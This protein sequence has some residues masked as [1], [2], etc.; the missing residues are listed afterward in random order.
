MWSFLPD[1]MMNYKKNGEGTNKPED[2][3]WITNQYKEDY[4]NDKQR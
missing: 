3:C 2:R 4:S 1:L